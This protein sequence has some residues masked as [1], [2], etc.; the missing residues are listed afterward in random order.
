MARRMPLSDDEIVARLPEV[1]KWVRKGDAIERS[2]TFRDFPGALAFINRV[3]EIAE[4]A[5]HHPD[6]HNSWASVTLRLTTHDK[7]GLTALD[8]DLAKKIDALA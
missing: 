1:P 6:I 8:F 5:N 2:W 7:G 3:G 4:T